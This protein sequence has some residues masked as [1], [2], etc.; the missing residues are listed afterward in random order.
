MAPSPDALLDQ[1]V[2]ASP[3]AA[4]YA[5][6]VERESALEMLGKQA[7]ARTAEE[8]A[9]QVEAEKRQGACGCRCRRREG[10]VGGREAGD[11]DAATAQKVAEQDQVAA[12]KKA[13]SEPG[14]VESVVKSSAF[15]SMLRS[16][17]TVLGREIAR[18]IF[19]TSRRR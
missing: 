17:G 14:V 13:A 10:T 3:L 12:E 4:K 7:Q 15:K 8:K 16:A 2:A 19:G 5:T 1:A 9:A 18:S 11:Q 6:A